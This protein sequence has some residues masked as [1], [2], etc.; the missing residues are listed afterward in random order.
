MARRFEHLIQFSKSETRVRAIPRR[1]APELCMNL[2]PISAPTPHQ[3]TRAA[4]AFLKPAA[5]SQKDRGRPRQMAQ[6]A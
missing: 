5:V 2:V 3:Q 4:S 1:D 6:N